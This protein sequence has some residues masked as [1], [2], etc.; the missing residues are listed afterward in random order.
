MKAR[1]VLYLIAVGVCAVLALLVYNAYY[2]PVSTS[3]TSLPAIAE[4]K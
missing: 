4:P 2:N 1:S 3:G